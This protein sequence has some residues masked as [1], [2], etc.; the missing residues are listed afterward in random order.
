MQFHSFPY[1]GRKSAHHYFSRVVDS[2]FSLLFDSSQNSIDNNRFDIILTQPKIVC[3]FKKQQLVISKNDNI[4]CINKTEALKE[5]LELYSNLYQL[6]DQQSRVNKSSPNLEIPFTSGLA[7][8][9][10]YDFGQWLETLTTNHKDDCDLPDALVGFYELPLIIDHVNQ[11]V[12]LYNYAY[13]ETQ[14]TKLVKIFSTATNRNSPSFK[15]KT[16]W[17]SNLTEAEYQNAFNRVKDYLNAG[18]CYQINLTQQFSANYEG[19][20]WQAY[21]HLSTLNSA[22]F[23]GYF[24]GNNFTLLSVSPERFIAVNSH[25]AITQPIKGTRPRSSDPL[26]DEKL[27]QELFLSEKDNAENLMIVDLLRN[28]LS[29]TAAKNSVKVTELFGLYSF[30]SV[31]HLISTIESQLKPSVSALDVFLKS[32]PGGSITGA[33]K[34][35]AMEI[36]DELEPTRRHFYCGSLAYFSFN[37][38]SDS[39]ILIRTVIATKDRMICSAGGGLVLDSNYQDEYLE[40][41]SKVSKILKPLEEL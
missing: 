38:R 4:T 39:N 26:E 7:G 37:N 20:L 9:F 27:K 12:T 15:V 10:G 1:L 23:S 24:N 22:P 25:H 29:K 2:P 17:S 28:D 30:P 31:H 5:F 21:Q 14:A 33:P 36:I 16:N 8:V 35:R 32:F 18:D 3:E 41:F 13:N 11:S 40:S 34:I 6:S 19:D